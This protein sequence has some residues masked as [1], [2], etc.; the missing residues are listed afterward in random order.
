M[1]LKRFLSMGCPDSSVASADKQEV[2]FPSTGAEEATQ[3]LSH[4]VTEC[5]CTRN[6]SS[7]PKAFHGTS[8]REQKGVAFLPRNPTFCSVDSCRI[9][10]AQPDIT[11]GALDSFGCPSSFC[12]QRGISNSSLI[13]RVA[14]D[15]VDS[16]GQ[17]SA[18]PLPSHKRR[19]IC[20]CMVS[21]FFFPSLGGVEMHIYELSLRL[22]RR[23]NLI[24]R[25]SCE[26]VGGS[27]L[28]KFPIVH[29]REH[30]SESGGGDS[31]G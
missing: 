28:Q 29:L 12:R 11:G 14:T 24:F 23:G 7:S 8:R 18:T 19:R 27:K 22:A 4:C 30:R 3:A 2:E 21:D 9:A 26:G 17:T 5:F 10:D 16:P 13:P 25:L 6:C 1:L 20:I 31:C 15:N